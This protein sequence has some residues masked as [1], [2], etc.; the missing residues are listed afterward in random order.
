M[1][2]EIQD[3]VDPKET[4]GQRLAC[5]GYREHVLSSCFQLMTTIRISLPEIILIR[6]TSDNISAPRAGKYLN[7]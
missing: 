5:I 1:T 4:R 2:E 7:Y 6:G 3:R